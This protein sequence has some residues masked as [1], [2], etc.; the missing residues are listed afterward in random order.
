MK[1]Y[2][3][4]QI[5]SA[6][7]RATPG[8]IKAIA[9][10]NRDVLDNDI[11]VPATGCAT[12]NHYFFC[13][14]HSVR[15]IWERHSPYKHRCPID[16]A[17]FSG[18]PYDGAW[19]RWLNGLNAKAC[20]ELAVLWLLTDESRYLDKVMAILLRYAQ[21]Y[22]DYEEH[23]GI[24]YNGPGKAN[25]QTLCEANCHTDFARGFDI[26]R[27]QLTQDQEQYIAERLLRCGAEFLMA[28]RGDQLHN[29]EVKI[30]AAIGI[31]G[32]VLEDKRYLDFAVNGPYGLR[33]QLEHGLSAGGLWF[34]G[35]LHYHY[36][37]LQA[38]FAFEKV[39][40]GSPFSLLTSPWYERMLTVPLQLLLPDMT[41]PAINDC[42]K[43]Q[44]K[45]GHPEIYEFAWYYYRTPIYGELL[46]WFY[47]ERPR[48]NID[49]LFY[50]APLPAAS[51]QP[52]QKTCHLPEPG[53]SFIR[54]ASGNAVCINHLPYGGEHDH[55]DRLD[56]LVYRD[57]KP[58]LP[59]LGTTGYGAPLHY[60]YY[61]NSFA[62]N[63]LCIN[64]Q[65]Q[66]PADPQVIAWQE[67]EGVTKFIGE[68]DWRHSATMPD[69]KTRIEWDP[70]SY[71]DVVFRRHVVVSCGLLIDLHEIENPHRQ[72]VSSVWH[73]RGQRAEEIVNHQGSYCFPSVS[74]QQED[75]LKGGRDIYYSAHCPLHVYGYSPED[76]TLITGRGP[77]N[78]ST[79]TLDY[80]I[81]R[82][83]RPRILHLCV[84]DFSGNG[85]VSAQWR[86]GTLWVSEAHSG[87]S[88]ALPL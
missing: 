17:H 21:Y 73:I 76:T 59:D 62:H 56:L 6:R 19:W 8:L 22:P 44:E 70:T 30:G 10:S 2:T 24:P 57:G 74:M 50:A 11:L 49:A 61:K 20:Y 36:Y 79:S 85:K 86:E 14:D 41:F 45:P 28:H 66:P 31:I 83:D 33:Y 29:H 47:T 13:P 5:Q 53:L 63:T 54:S 46:R 26:I 87:F 82:S 35:S 15:L 60:G 43:G 16:G 9:A 71:R 48:E 67:E 3:E 42:V 51:L 23:G 34:E 4:A 78:P 37:A 69:S 68:V 72:E 12:W 38:F 40:V 64:G 52:P 39:A 84:L 58:L 1:Q 80:F 77:D 32:A 55:Y 88:C 65:N 27:A 18:E 81:L 7:A 25:A 75:R